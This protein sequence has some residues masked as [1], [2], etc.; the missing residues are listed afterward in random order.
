MLISLTFD[1]G[2]NTV[3]TPQVLD[4]LEENGVRASFFLIGA[5]I[6][7]ESAKV[8]R[9]AFEMGCDIENH[10]VTH[11]AL[12]K[13]SP[14][15]ILREVDGCTEKIVAITGR[16]PRFFRPPYIAVNQ[17][18]YDTVPLPMICG[19]GCEDWVPQVSAQTRIERIL[20]AAR[21]GD[22]LL[23]HDMPGNDNTV[24]ALRTVIPELKKRGFRFVTCAQ[25][26]DELGIAPQR[27]SMYSN[28]LE[29]IRP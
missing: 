17:M 5:A 7:E 27:G 13:L 15:E 26:F 16:A 12:D 4:I 1:D 24:T 22:L 11:P 14:G 19:V 6:T 10:S 21:H 20:A 25:L 18:V 3:T 23:L 2:P 8:A 29:P 28:A 9:R